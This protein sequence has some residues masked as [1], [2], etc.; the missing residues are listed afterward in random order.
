MTLNNKT[1]YI[2]KHEKN[3]KLYKKKT[4][5]NKEAKKMENECAYKV[6]VVGSSI[7]LSC[8]PWVLELLQV[9]T[10]SEVADLLLP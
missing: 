8:F 3:T 4:E 7:G 2:Y 9:P 10:V 1:F 5:Q 6:L